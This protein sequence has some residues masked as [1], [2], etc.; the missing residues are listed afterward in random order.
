MPHRQK[1]PPPVVRPYSEYRA[2]K[3]SSGSDLGPGGC[4]IMVNHSAPLASP[5]TDEEIGEDRLCSIEPSLLGTPTEDG[6]CPVV[7]DLLGLSVANIPSRSHVTCLARE[8]FLN[9]ENVTVDD[10]EQPRDELSSQGEASGA[11]IGGSTSPTIGEALSPTSTFDPFASHLSPSSSASFH[12]E[13]PQTL[14]G[15]ATSSSS[16]HRSSVDTDDCLDDFSALARERSQPSGSSVT[17]SND[18]WMAHV[19]AGQ[20][21]ANGQPPSALYMQ[22]GASPSVAQSRVAAEGDSLVHPPNVSCA[23][24]FNAV[25]AS[26]Q[27]GRPSSESTGKRDPLR[28]TPFDDLL[29]SSISH[30][31][32][33]NSIPASA[34]HMET[35]PFSSGQSPQRRSSAAATPVKPGPPV[36]PYRR[37]THGGSPTIPEMAGQPGL[38]FD[39]LA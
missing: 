17:S 4:D 2:T 21:F 30:L 20:H 6:D 16:R 27:T 15:L 34:G 33:Q 37:S 35:N 11:I 14:A 19:K 26:P 5:L 1:R 8:M 32:S 28:P 31:P 18:P 22:C 23:P 25:R 10:P 38:E 9:F 24:Q 3:S 29:E 12:S 36:K 7:D 39:P 13:P